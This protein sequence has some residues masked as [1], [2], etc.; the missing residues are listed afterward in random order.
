MERDPGVVP[1]RESAA[2]GAGGR[3]DERRGC[4]PRTQPPGVCGGGRLRREDTEEEKPKTEPQW[5]P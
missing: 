4:L 5:K 2:Q 3:R 1:Q